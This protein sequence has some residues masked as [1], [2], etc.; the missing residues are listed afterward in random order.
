MNAWGDICA[1]IASV[2]CPAH[3]QPAFMKR[4]G[5]PNCNRGSEH[6]S[7]SP[8]SELRDDGRFDPLPTPVPPRTLVVFNGRSVAGILADARRAFPDVADVLVITRDND[9]LPPPEG[10]P[11]CPVSDFRPA[12]NPTYRP[13]PEVE[14]LVV[15][16][17]GTTAQQAPVLLRL[18]RA[19]SAVRVFDLQRDGIREILF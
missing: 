14:Y 5:C 6:I 11:S 4:W 9:D 2:V 13:D 17:G 8:A 16:N 3:T 19:R 7:L 15:A 18:G 12:E 1:P 10:V